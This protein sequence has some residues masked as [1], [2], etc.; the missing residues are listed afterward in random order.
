MK[1]GKPRAKQ[2]GVITAI[3]VCKDRSPKSQTRKRTEK[4]LL[5]V[6]RSIHLWAVSERGSQPD[7]ISQT[8]LQLG[9]VTWLSTGQWHVSRNYVC[10]FHATALKEK[11]V[12]PSVSLA[13]PMEIWHVE[14]HFGACIQEQLL[15]SG[16]GTRDRDSGSSPLW[17][18]LINQPLILR[19]SY[20]SEINSIFLASSNVICIPL[21]HGINPWKKAS[22]CM[23]W[24]ESREKKS[25]EGSTIGKASTGGRHDPVWRLAHRNRSP[26][27]HSHLLIGR[28]L[29]TVMSTCKYNI[30]FLT[31]WPLHMLSLALR[32]PTPTPTI[33]QTWINSTLLSDFCR[34]LASPGRGPL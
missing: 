4:R 25:R 2:T 20:E 5:A 22:R 21:I 3:L 23:R 7:Y 18:H 11:S 26:Q 28:S 30:L 9:V 10:D 15:R 17:C 13:C 31:S 19:Q 29:L 12:C 33:P 27:H 6:S 1:D 16:G 32:S 8:A 24:E 14:S 34:N